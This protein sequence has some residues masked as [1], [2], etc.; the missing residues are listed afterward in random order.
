MAAALLLG[1]CA[2]LPHGQE[3]A[4]LERLLA[5]DA[6]QR[7]VAWQQLQHER[8]AERV[9]ERAYLMS[10]PGH[11]GYDPDNALLLL[12]SLS[13]QVSDPVAQGLVRERIATLEAIAACRQRQELLERRLRR[14][15][16]IEKGYQDGG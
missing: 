6:A 14:L 16:E 5:A 11:E 7:A 3:R 13:G 2:V 8:N 12:R 4:G 10:L 1:G 9:L 15:I